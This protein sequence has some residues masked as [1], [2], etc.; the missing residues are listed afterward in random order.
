ME[1]LGA[2]ASIAIIWVLSGVLMYEAIQR[3]QN[4]EDVKGWIMSLI[5]FVGVI[6]NVLLLLLLHDVPVVG[7]VPE[8]IF[9]FSPLRTFS[10]LT[11]RDVFR[12]QP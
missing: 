1:I 2:L 7:K 6:V 5:A 11:P 9:I 10:G 8:T 4:P 3:I 12:P